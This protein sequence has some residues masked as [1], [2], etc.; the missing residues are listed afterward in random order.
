MRPLD[1]AVPRGRGPKGMSDVPRRDCCVSASC[2]GAPRHDAVHRVASVA[3]ID[4]GAGNVRR[5]GRSADGRSGRQTR[6]PARRARPPGPG[7]FALILAATRVGGEVLLIA[8]KPCP[9]DVALVMILQQDLA[10]AKGT[11]VPVGLTRPAINDLGSIDAFA[12]GVGAG[13]GK[14]LPTTAALMVRG[15]P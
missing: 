2:R 8:F 10:V 7:I 9:V 12:A 15:D 13:I 6:R 11:I 14:R 3:A 4:G 5:R 1:R